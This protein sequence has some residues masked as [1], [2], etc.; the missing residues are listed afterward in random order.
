[1][2]FF[3][4]GD[5]VTILSQIQAGWYRYTSEWR[6]K[7]DGTILPRFGFAGVLWPNECVA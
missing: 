5:E 7:A 4:D 1:V 2:G 6:F 3:V